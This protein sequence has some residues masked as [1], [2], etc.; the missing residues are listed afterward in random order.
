MNGGDILAKVITY[1]ADE[2]GDIGHTEIVPVIANE[3]CYRESLEMLKM[4]ECVI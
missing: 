3:P 1:D 4:R 2:F